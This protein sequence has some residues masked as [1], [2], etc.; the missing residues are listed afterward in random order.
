ML[1]AALTGKN[2]DHGRAGFT[3]IEILVVILIIA[4]VLA[5]LLQSSQAVREM[6][7]RVKCANNLKNIG[8]AWHHHHLINGH[9][10]AGGWGW[11]WV[12]DPDQ[13]VDQNQPGGWLY[14][15]LPQIEET[16]LHDSGKGQPDPQKRAALAQMVG[17]P[18]ILFHCPTRRASQLYTNGYQPYNT[19]KP[20]GYARTDY[21]ANCG[22]APHDEIYPGPGSLSQGLDPNYGWPDTSGYTGVCFQR[23]MIRF[24]DITRGADETYMAGEKYLN[25]DQYK[26][27]SSGADN[28]NMYVGFDNDIFRDTA[29]PPQHDT[30]GVSNTFIFGGAHRDTFNMLYCSGGVRQ[31]PYKIDPNVFKT[32]GNRQ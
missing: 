28:E 20:T 14:N 27:G 11:S 32:N 21:A 7:S 30:K 24:S 3:L 6:A 8:E 16:N 1:R 19:N 12:G 31:V 23:S 25:P 5:L 18:L 4:I 15:I 26:D 17:T 2:R 9:L 29:N 22:S 10:P 13:G